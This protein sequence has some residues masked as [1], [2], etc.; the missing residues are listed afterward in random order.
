MFGIAQCESA[1]SHTMSAEEKGGETVS[2]IL[3]W[4]SMLTKML[5]GIRKVPLQENRGGD[6]L[7]SA[8]KPFEDL[9]RCGGRWCPD[10]LA[11]DD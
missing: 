11:S 3:F 8:S 2:G 6:E 10:L 4:L 7:P 1:A 9:M 5:P